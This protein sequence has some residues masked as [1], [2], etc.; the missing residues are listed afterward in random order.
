MQT[1]ASVD[2]LFR[3]RGD[4]SIID[5]L[6]RVEV[7]HPAV[8]VIVPPRLDGCVGTLR[9]VFMRR[10][11]RRRARLTTKIVFQVDQIAIDVRNGRPSHDSELH[12]TLVDIV[13]LDG[14][15]HKGQ[16]TDGLIQIGLVDARIIS[17]SVHAHY[18]FRPPRYPRN[19]DRCR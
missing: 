2:C 11:L 1:S 16:R 12:S 3:I 19:V 4:R 7:H 15:H 5:H 10:A 18:D 13:I 17:C 9:D 14:I 6:T 8:N